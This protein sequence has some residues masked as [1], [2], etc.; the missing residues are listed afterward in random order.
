[1]AGQVSLDIRIEHAAAELG[2]GVVSAVRKDD[3]VGRL[4]PAIEAHVETGAGAGSQG[5]YERALAGVPVSQINHYVSSV[6]RH[7]YFPHPR[8]MR[9][10]NGRFDTHFMANPRTATLSVEIRL[11]GTVVSKLE[12]T[13]LI[14]S[15]TDFQL[16]SAGQWV[17]QPGWAS[18]GFGTISPC[19][20]MNTPWVRVVTQLI[21]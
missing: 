3:V 19:R 11:S 2:E 5:V 13:L 21:E 15:T 12:Q 6:N 20:E 10:W 1:M 17:R 16:S 18:S 9:S 14:A 7:G 4:P 8:P